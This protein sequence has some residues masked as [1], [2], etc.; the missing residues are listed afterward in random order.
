[1]ERPPAL[2]TIEISCQIRKA[3]VFEIALNNPL[4]EVAVFEASMDGDGL[5]GDPF[6]TLD[7][8]QTKNYEVYFSPQ[9][10]GKYKGSVSLINEKLGEAWYSL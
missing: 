8:H 3:A 9:R 5:I 2:R 10:L 6:I 7:P 4:N 1:M